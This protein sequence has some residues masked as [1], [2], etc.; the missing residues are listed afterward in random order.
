MYNIYIFIIIT[1]II[2]SVVLQSIKITEN[3]EK[4]NNT[5]IISDN[6]GNFDDINMI[7]NPIIFDVILQQIN[8]NN[9]VPSILLNNTDLEKLKIYIDPYVQYYLFNDTDIENYNYLDKKGYFVRISPFK[10]GH[11]DCAWNFV[12]KTIAY[13]CMTDYYFIMAVIKGH[14]LDINKIKLIKINFND[15]VFYAETF[16]KNK[17]DI[18]ITY[19]IQDSQYA[20]LLQDVNYNMTGFNNMDLNRIKAFYPFVNEEYINLNTI[21]KKKVLAMSLDNSNN[22]LVPSMNYVY[23][24]NIDITDFD[25]DDNIVENFITRLD[26]DKDSLDPLYLCYGDIATENKAQCNSPIDVD[27]LAKRRYTVW[28]KICIKDEDCPFF[29]GNKTYEN[30]YGGCNNGVCE[31]PVGVQRLGFTKYSTQ[32]FFKP[33]CYG[34]GDDYKDCCDDKDTMPDYVFP[35]DFEKR[36]K[37]GKETIVS[38][39]K[40]SF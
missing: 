37:A 18:L 7:V 38:N 26:I 32:G 35:N 24:D 34:C 2:Y 9:S 29:N 20:S 1:I 16:L 19:V 25:T 4:I 28:D 39:I 40:Y 8:K 23:I 36:K 3:F 11:D 30:K 5:I 12:N 10:L 14:H 27:G 21:F 6:N 13:T 22:L 17:I 15:M 33:L 31:M